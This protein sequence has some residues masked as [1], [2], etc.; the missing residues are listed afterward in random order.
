MVFKSDQP[1]HIEYYIQQDIY[2]RRIHNQ[3][4]SPSRSRVLRRKT[5]GRQLTVLRK[6]NYRNT[7]VYNIDSWGTSDT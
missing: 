5:A 6:V 4:M 3:E 2:P 1:G 7:D